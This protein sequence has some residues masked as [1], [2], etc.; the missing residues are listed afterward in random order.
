MG[1]KVPLVASLP[2]TYAGRSLKP[3]DRFEASAY[4]ARILKAIKKAQDAP[5]PET[6]REYKRRDMKAEGSE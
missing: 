3:G 2:F 6:K 4:D 1:E 5:Q